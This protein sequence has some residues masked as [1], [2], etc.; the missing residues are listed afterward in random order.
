[1]MLCC[2]GLFGG[3]ALGQ[4]LGG[5]WTLIAPAAGFGIGFLADMKMMKGMHGQ[6]RQQ[7]AP[8][9]H[10]QENA[11]RD[12]GEADPAPIRPAEAPAINGLRE[13]QDPGR[14]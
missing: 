4:A 13:L 7:A 2:V 9:L 1:M 6:G 8:T 10:P 12:A 11:G 3:V 14:A 5:P